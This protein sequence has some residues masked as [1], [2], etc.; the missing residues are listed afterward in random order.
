MLC[1]NIPFLTKE[2]RTNRSQLHIV[3]DK[4]LADD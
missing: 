3:I 1:F 2:T 4:Q